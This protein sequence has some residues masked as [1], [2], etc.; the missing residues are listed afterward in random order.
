[1]QTRWHSFDSD[2]AWLAGALTHVADA[3]RA[4][5][6]ARGEFHL[7][8]AGGETPRRLY[9]ALLEETHEWSRWRLWFGDER[10]LPPGHA[11]RNSTLA[12]KLAGRVDAEHVHPIPGELGPRA[13]A[14]AYA[15]TLADMA[16]FDL[17][18]L[19]LGEDGHTASLFPGYRLDT[20]A[21]AVPVFDAPKPPPERVS[22]SPSRL[23]RAHQV[24]FLVR[25]AGK[26]V[27]VAR[28]RAGDTLPAAD[29]QP[30]SGV[31]VLLGLEFPPS[32]VVS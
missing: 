7:V 9:Q 13:A 28:W 5:L 32:G 20:T 21:D 24:L 31:D 17:V 14:A 12:E 2:S 18:L 19:G 29:I 4:A 15:E 23:A 22:L 16:E 8:L 25:G 3:E 27:A 11:E 1:M 10:C 6:A 26:R 30:A